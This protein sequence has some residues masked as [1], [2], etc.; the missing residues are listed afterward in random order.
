MSQEQFLQPEQQSEPL[1]D[2]PLKEAWNIKPLIDSLQDEFLQGALARGVPESDLPR[3]VA[4]AMTT[5]LLPR[6]VV[7]MSMRS[8]QKSFTLLDGVIPPE[9]VGV[10]IYRNP[11]V[12]GYMR[13]SVKMNHGVTPS[14]DDTYSLSR[15]I[16]PGGDA[17]TTPFDTSILDA[18]KAHIEPPTSETSF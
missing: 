14:E 9:V 5:G 8:G 15:V 12:P 2:T 4:E 3:L 18:L 13:A 6:V 10:E 17:R 7:N 11:S 16:V 1:E